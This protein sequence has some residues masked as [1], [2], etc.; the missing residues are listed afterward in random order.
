[1][2]CALWYFSHGSLG[3]VVCSSEDAAVKQA[4]FMNED[5][6][7]A[8]DGVQMQDGSYIK[9]EEWPALRAAEAAAYGAILQE[10][11]SAAPRPV[12]VQV[13]PPFDDRQGRTAAVGWDVVPAWMR[14]QIASR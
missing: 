7:A 14:D 10:S 12:T 4:Q 2:E 13:R 8:P 6:W 9:V 5:G 3:F 1:M 11:R